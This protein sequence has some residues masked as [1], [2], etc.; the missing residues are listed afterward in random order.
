MKH[1]FQF[2]FSDLFVSEESTSRHYGGGEGP[3]K[4]AG[5]DY[6]LRLESLER[7]AASV[8]TTTYE[9]SDTNQCRNAG[10]QSVSGG[11]GNHADL[12]AVFDRIDGEKRGI[13]GI[14]NKQNFTVIDQPFNCR[15]GYVTGGGKIKRSRCVGEVNVKIWMI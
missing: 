10:H 11:L 15:E 5:G 8:L 6:L 9:K 3:K 7:R 2:P 4:S 13:D 12:P 1:A 14:V